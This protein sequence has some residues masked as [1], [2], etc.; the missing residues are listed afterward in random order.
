ESGL[1]D[2]IAK[3]AAA[4]DHYYEARALNDLGMGGVAR[5]R[6]DEALQR[7][8]RVL[9]FDD[10]EQLTVYKAALANAGI[11]Y[12]RLGEFDRAVATQRRAVDLQRTGAPRVDFER[13]LGELGHTFMQR[14]DPRRGL[15]Y[16]RQA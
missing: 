7:F 8:E 5:S 9:S 13:G 16:L 1:N 11:C 12:A 3:A 14:G 6:W 4:G 10:L 2:V 15:P